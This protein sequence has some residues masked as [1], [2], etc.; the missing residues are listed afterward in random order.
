MVLANLLIG[1]LMIYTSSS[2][3]I[4]EKDSLCKEY[5]SNNK[6]SD[7][8]LQ[9]G[10]LENL[11]NNCEKNLKIAFF[12]DHIKSHNTPAYPL[13]QSLIATGHEI[14]YFGYIEDKVPIEKIGG[15]FFLYPDNK[16]IGHTS[17]NMRQVT[18]NASGLFNI[19]ILTGLA[20]IYAPWFIENFKNEKFDAVIYSFFGIWGNAIS[21][22]L[23]VKSICSNPSW[24]RKPEMVEITFTEGKD[25][26]N[27]ILKSFND[28]YHTFYIPTDI[29][30]CWN[31]DKVIV[32]SSQNLF[33]AA[34]GSEMPNPDKFFFYNSRVPDPDSLSISKT[35]SQGS[36]IYCT[37]GTMF[38]WNEE[39][40]T[41]SIKYLSKTDY[42]LIISAGGN[43][44]IYDKLKTL[45]HFDNIEIHLFVN[46]TEILHNSAVFISHGG[47]SSFFE[48]L[49]YRVPIIVVPQGGDQFAIAKAV[50]K[51]KIGV[52]LTKFKENLDEGISLAMK[53]IE[54][55]YGLY[56]KNIENVIRNYL[57]GK[58]TEE[59]TSDIT[60]FILT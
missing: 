1:L 29:I 49:F 39:F 13:V 59:V 2:N 24:L 46:Q 17:A 45:Y 48:T 43:K 7:N 12:G 9:N 58:T 41:S 37:L 52:D 25:Q 5:D 36:T 53:E 23:N 57:V 51:F 47:P 34:L 35:L 21:K 16:G 50:E 19:K 14:W 33:Q 55:N 22:F 31:A 30:T 3:T 40:Y 11:H 27:S 20:E 18:R 6:I 32:Y 54:A 4:D 60:D 28:K 15:K 10:C 26:Q 8:S 38:N 44:E 42:K 56:Q